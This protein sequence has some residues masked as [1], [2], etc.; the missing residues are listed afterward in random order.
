MNYI[1]GKYALAACSLIDHLKQKG[2]DAYVGYSANKRRDKNLIALVDARYEQEVPSEWN[3]IPVKIGDPE[4][5]VL[6]T[7]KQ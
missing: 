6:I 1:R 3:G 2:I 7:E 5:A 4:K